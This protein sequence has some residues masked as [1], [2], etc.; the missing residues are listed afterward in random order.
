MKKL[1]FLQNIKRFREVE[2]TSIAAENWILEDKPPEGSAILAGYQTRGAGMAGN[3]WESESGKN[4]LVS[5]ILY[6]EFLQAADQFMI[7]KVVSLAV[8]ECV[9][10]FLVNQHVCIKWPND[11][12][13][14]KLKIAGILSRNAVSGN[15][16]NH[17]VVGVG[18]NVNQEKFSE[19]LPNATSLKL[20]AGTDFDL[21]E[22][23]QY[24]GK[25]FEK[26]Y[27]LLIF[28]QLNQIDELYLRSLYKI[29]ILAPFIS[30]GQKFYGKITGVSQFGFLQI[31]VDGHKKEF[32]IKDVQFLNE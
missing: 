1:P 25:Q 17:S 10:F 15:N 11:I 23:L 18:L 26:F 14:G 19:E 20:N 8:Q 28:G 5:F 27:N 29:N 6:P 31:F 3:T 2:S 21:E 30:N 13:I 4:L 24:L 16:L 7:N 22:V 32:D 9:R 12:Y